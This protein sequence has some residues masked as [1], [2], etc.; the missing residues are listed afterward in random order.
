MSNDSLVINAVEGS[1]SWGDSYIYF[2][3]KDHI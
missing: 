3:D 1:N 2:G